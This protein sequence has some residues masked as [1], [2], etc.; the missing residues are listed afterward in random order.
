MIARAARKGLRVQ[1]VM[2]AIEDSSRERRSVLISA[3]GTVQPA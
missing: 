1:E 3:R 2:G